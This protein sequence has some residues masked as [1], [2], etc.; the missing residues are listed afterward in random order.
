MSAASG[1]SFSISTV[2]T[3]NYLQLVFSTGTRKQNMRRVYMVVAALVAVF[4]SSSNAVPTAGGTKTVVESDVSLMDHVTEDP[5]NGA[6][7]KNLL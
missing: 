6:D 7:A 1:P 4:A 3:T 2:C 5:V